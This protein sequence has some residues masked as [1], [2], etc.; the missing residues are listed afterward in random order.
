MA[1]KIMITSSGYDPQL[2][3]HDNYNLDSAK[4]GFYLCRANA[5]LLLRAGSRTLCSLPVSL[6]ASLF[7][8][9]SLSLR[10]R[11]RRLSTI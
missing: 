2:G 8:F 6:T 1:G 11:S 9:A 3:K 10:K 5:T 4:S 7:G